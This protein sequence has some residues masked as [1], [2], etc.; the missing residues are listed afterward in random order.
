[1]KPLTLRVIQD[2]H[3]ALAAMLRSIPLLLAE[4][5][6]QQ[7]LPDFA[8]LR[9]ML[10]YV[11]EFPERLHHPKES[12]LL[13]PVLRARAPE[14]RE[15]LDQLDQDHARGER[16]I[17]E[18]E[19]SLLAFEMMGEPRREAFEALAQRYVQ[20]YLQHMAIEEREI[21]PLAQK[22]LQPADWYDLD[23]AFAA[24]RDPLAGHAAD[25]TYRAVLDRILNALPAPLGYGPALD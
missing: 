2:E 24:N 10:F 7:T 22:V 18:L 3:Q 19:H 8:A 20:A 14:C 5:R 11:D 13:F 16:A 17:R 15:V 4:H 23:E 9:A 1:M 12:Q 6:R 25:E 21:L